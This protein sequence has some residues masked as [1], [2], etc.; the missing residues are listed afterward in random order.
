MLPPHRSKELG[1]AMLVQRPAEP[2]GVRL[3]APVA[4]VVEALAVLVLAIGFLVEVA[5]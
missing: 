2:A 5:D 4:S 1:S 3:V